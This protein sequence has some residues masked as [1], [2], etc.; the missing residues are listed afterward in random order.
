MSEKKVLGLTENTR[1][2]RDIR[3]GFEKFYSKFNKDKAVLIPVAS[4]IACMT[5]LLQAHADTILLTALP[6]S[7]LFAG[8]KITVPFEKPYYDEKKGK[9]FF[10]FGNELNTNK[11]IWFSDS[12]ARRHILIFGTTGSGKSES[13]IGIVANS[14]AQNSAFCYVDGKADTGLFS[15]LFS[16][17]RRFGREDD[18]LVINYMVGTTR[19]D[20]RREKKLSN[21]LNPF[22][23]ATADALSELITSLLPSGG[24][25]DGIWKDRASV[26]MGALIKALCAL[27]D[28]GHLLLDVNAIRQYFTLEQIVALS[29]DTRIKESYREGLINYVSNLPGYQEG[30]SEQESTVYEQNGYVVMQFQPCF[31]MLADTYGHVMK[32]QLASVEFN[33]VVLRRRNLICLLPA[34]E[35]SPSNLSNLGKIIISSV[36]SMMA[37]ALGAE[38]EGL[39]E[40]TLDAKPTNGRTYQCVFDEYGYYSVEGAAVMPAQAR[41]IGFSLTFAGQDYQ[42]FKKGSEEEAASIKANCAIK[43]CMTLEDPGET[44]DIFIKGAGE[45]I[46]VAETGYEREK[47]LFGTNYIAKKDL[48]FEKANRIEPRDLKDQYPGQYHIINMDNLA[49]GKSFYANPKQ[50]KE[51]RVNSFV[52]IKPPNADQVRKVK[53]AIFN[54]KSAFKNT[55]NETATSWK[56]KK[57]EQDST[58]SSMISHIEE[59]DTLK[60]AF[61]TLAAT[62]NKID[63]IN[64]MLVVRIRELEEHLNRSLDE[65]EEYSNKTTFE[66]TSAITEKP[67]ATITKPKV[68][69]DAIKEKVLSNSKKIVNYTDW[70]KNPLM[71]IGL[72]VDEITENIKSNSESI[73]NNWE[74]NGHLDIKGLYF[75]IGN[76]DIISDVASQQVIIDSNEKHEE[77]QKLK[78]TN[79]V[80][81]SNAASSIEEKLKKLTM[82]SGELE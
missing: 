3:S 41:G 79:E 51:L 52:E 66:E 78:E 45:G 28:N 12:E 57:A 74:Q 46:R 31:G 43:I 63:I 39:T 26:F 67:R 54:Y 58:I 18:L 5:P 64:N 32:T 68:G 49:R 19:T 36:K 72:E 21:T 61:F 29:K 56:K 10:F 76:Q 17:C 13:L 14:L 70:D 8:R 30:K 15:K 44:A 73:L 81:I 42:A 65:N 27:R 82:T 7:Y 1:T 77:Y 2:D 40:Y 55:G 22:A 75:D 53:T 60:K 11:E 20:V 25:S 23:N 33:D 71:N 6:V 4:A 35:K 59:E 9:G 47:G 37:G 80:N 50:L 34:L 69:L 24:S 16:L 62:K 38:L 48:T